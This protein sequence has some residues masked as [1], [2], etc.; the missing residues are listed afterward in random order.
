[1]TLTRYLS[2]AFAGRFLAVL[3]A[4]AALLQLL[5]LLDK[6]S[7]VLERGQGAADLLTYIALRLPMI[8]NQLVPLAVLVGALGAFMT[9]AQ[10]N[11]V[12]A[13]RSVGASPW[14]FL[15]LLLP[16]V[17]VIVLLH[18][19]LLDQVVPRSE[20][21]LQDW[22]AARAGP[23]AQAED[24]P[25]K[26]VWMRVGDSIVSIAAVDDRGRRLTGVT[27]VTRNEQGRATGR[28]VARNAEWDD[29]R[30]TLRDAEA[31][32]L[33]SNGA[34]T[35]DHRDALPWPDGPSPDNVAFVAK[36]TQ[37]LSLQRI[38]SIL[39]GVWS[40]T[41]PRAYYETQMQKTFSIPASSFVMLLLAQPALHG[42]RR[43]RRF[44]SGIAAGLALGLVFLLFQGLLS[45]L[46]QADT[47]SPALAVWS[48]LVL[49]GCIGGTILLSLEE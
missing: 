39:D 6:A 29:G 19:L 49:F 22:W 18:L 34:Q 10:H 20:R 14:L 5:D 17:A 2:R 30:W 33:R 26:P 25:A 45:A 47:L 41:K 7:V 8:V 24:A 27:I 46:A 15:R 3:L 21:V 43:S 42:I 4:F 16:A 1:M 31:L 9:L 23:T 12:V 37:F 48:P 40:G 35:S 32:S 28:I 38:R 13:L 36:P 44:G 11:E